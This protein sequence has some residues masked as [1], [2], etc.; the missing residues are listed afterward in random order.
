MTVERATGQ[1]AWHAMPAEAVCARLGTGPD[2]LT[3]SEARRR[4][5]AHG[6]NRLREAARQ[7]PL[8]RF[9]AQFN[10]TLIYFLLAAALMSI[11]LG[12][13]VDGL[14]IV[15]VVVV[16][17]VVG[18]LQEGKAEQALNAIRDMIAPHAIVLREGERHRIDTREIVPGDVVLLDA[19]DKVPADLRL[20]RARG[21]TVDEAILTGESVPAEKAEP[22]VDAGAALADRFPVLYSGTIVATGQ[23]TGV[24][25]A[26][27]TDTEIGRISRLIGDVQVL[28][29]PLLA[30]INQFGRLTTWFAISTAAALFV[31][32]V[33]ARGYDWVD[34]LVV[35]VA[36]A[37]SVVPE[38]LPAVITI[39]LAIGVRRMAARNAVVRRLPAVETLGA[40]SVICSDKTGTLTK[41][42]M[43]ARRTVTMAG[44]TRVTG[45]GYA[46]AGTIEGADDPA[47][48]RLIRAGLLC[49][50]ARLVE[51]DGAWTVLGDPMEGAL[52]ALA[53]K[54]GLHPE[55][56]RDAW[57][58]LDE[59]PFDAQHRFMA[60]LHTAP[61][62]SR[63]VF[64]KGAPER[65]LAMCGSVAGG[66]AVDPAHWLRRIDEA[67]ANGERLLGLATRAAD[68]IERLD[69]ASVETGLTFL[70]LVGFIDPPRDEAIAA[71]A[72][73]RSAG[74]AVKMITG[75][76]QGTA[77]AIARQLAI[78]DDPKVVK[79]TVLDGLTDEELRVV[80]EETSVFART[81][82][83]HKLRIVRAL[84]ANG[85][86]VAMTGDGVND[87]PAVK[88]ADVGVA[89]GRKGT[90]AAKEAAQMVLVDDNFA[91]I[92]AAVNEGRTVYD[93]I[94]KVIGW[95]LPTNG[96]EVLVV[97]LA[98][99]LGLTLPMTPV[100]ILW[101]NLILTITLG[102]VLAFEPAEPD[103]MRRPPRPRN[104]PILSR[105]LVWRIV[106]VSALFAL[107]VFGI[108]EY[109]MRGGLGEDVARTM[110]VNT[111]VVM[112]I[113][114]LFNVRYLHKTSFSL[115]GAMGTP[116]VLAA[117]AAVVAAQLAFTYLPVMNALFDSAP[118]AFTD[119]LLV[120]AIGVVTMA[121]LETEKVLTRRLWPAAL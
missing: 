111:I 33:L 7:H 77:L 9:L 13:L 93:N 99:F 19:G 28:T 29:T 31:F 47:R 71:V 6:P 60:T 63:H 1:D 106:F 49:N 56:E 83:E 5:K 87:A 101:I 32:A 11:V 48:E 42:E 34:A 74:I 86:I 52:V 120:M 18:Y 105:F 104:A 61:D 67:A 65:V 100:Q 55:P 68:G 114:Y 81:T 119:G 121:V 54:S 25:V 22:P 3:L 108:F 15:A 8:L 64:V 78:A 91:S 62:G 112:E 82:P 113:F 10:N 117:V 115:V 118:V 72:E 16:N 70:G 4:L 58:R 24:A 88:Q 95:T 110:V 109:A 53:A 94:R 66:D 50:D 41:N 102:L 45:S 76:H 107:G 85:R 27:G 97:I 59:I 103:V 57:T 2:G 14:V 80:A 39:T 35:V 26:T 92:V 79:G 46:P 12:H 96:G 17:A 23:A 75:D 43:T 84:Q 20:I 30:Q 37:V 40:T 69:F 90:E 21:L 116:P 89:M 44:I 51:R 73:C 38:G 36:L 98:I